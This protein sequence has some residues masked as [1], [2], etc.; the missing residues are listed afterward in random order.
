M[1]F[2]DLARFGLSYTFLRDN[3]EA[4]RPPLPSFDLFWALEGIS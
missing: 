2:G 4:L 1:N 3:M